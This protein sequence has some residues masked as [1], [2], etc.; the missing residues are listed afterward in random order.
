MGNR[1]V[2]T[3]NKNLEEIG[4]YLHWNGGRD[5]IEAFLAYCKLKGYRSPE[6]DCYGWTCLAGVI[7]N[8]FSNGMSCGLCIAKNLDCNNWDNGTYI[9]KDWL[10][11]DR[12]FFNAEEQDEYDLEEFIF[13]VD[14]AMPNKM[15]LTHEEKKNIHKVIAEVY[16]AR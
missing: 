3:T 8:Y 15:K 7:F 14:E 10:I 1:A 5:S 16:A 13:S 11:V 9:I 2:I 6:R 12:M 4:I